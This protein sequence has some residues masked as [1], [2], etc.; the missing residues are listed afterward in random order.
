MPV[1]GTMTKL[2]CSSSKR[3]FM[4]ADLHM[5]LDIWPRTARASSSAQMDW[6]RMAS[7]GGS[8]G[9]SFGQY[10]AATFR[11]YRSPLRISSSLMNNVSIS[12]MRLRSSG[13]VMRLAGSG[14]NVASRMSEHSTEM[15][16][17]SRR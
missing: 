14:W 6:Q 7:A 17:I 3:M 1:D 5:G 10:E 4:I 11:R 9:G 2:P 16:M 12:R 13:M 15:G 8:M